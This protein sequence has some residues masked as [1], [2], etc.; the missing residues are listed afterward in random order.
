MSTKKNK[1]RKKT[2]SNLQNSSN[3]GQ[4]ANRQKTDSQ[5]VIIDPSRIRSQYTINGIQ[6]GYSDYVGDKGVVDP[7][8]NNISNP[9]GAY[10]KK[11][12]NTWIPTRYDQDAENLRFYESMFIQPKE[13]EQSVIFGFPAKQDFYDNY[14]IAPSNALYDPYSPAYQ[15]IQEVFERN[16]KA[17]HAW[18]VSQADAKVRATAP[19]SNPLQLA[20]GLGSIYAYNYPYRSTN[21]SYN[22]RGGSYK[23][24]ASQYRD[25]VEDMSNKGNGKYQL[26]FPEESF[27]SGEVHL[28]DVS[29]AVK[30]AIQLLNFRR[31]TPEQQKSA[32]QA[33][34]NFKVANLDNNAMKMFYRYDSPDLKG[35]VFSD[36]NAPNVATINIGDNP[37][38]ISTQI[39][40]FSHQL[41]KESPLSLDQSSLLRLAYKEIPE[42]EQ[43]T[44]NSEL[45]FQILYPSGLITRSVQEQNDYIDDLDDHTL[46]DMYNNVNGYTDIKEH[47]HY[48]KFWIN[49]LK[50]ALKS[51]PLYEKVEVPSLKHLNYPYS[52]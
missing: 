39:H 10:V 7:K 30:S 42:E 41:D 40:E 47:A 8:G 17:R 32:T 12:N 23:N 9:K 35:F 1:L 26:N 45:R 44:T 4:S 52:Y 51:V 3:H 31:M 46:I 27:P 38:H 5:V 36:E 13:S 25:I 37:N 20:A 28:K 18:R 24:L 43:R 2:S 50:D 48:D 49:N 33:L 11:I 15:T 34:S 19:S 21:R 16:S 29:P 6:Y 22:L 14:Q